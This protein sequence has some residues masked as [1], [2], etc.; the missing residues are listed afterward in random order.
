MLGYIRK[1][2]P[3]GVRIVYEVEGKSVCYFL[4]NYRG[5]ERA[6]HVAKVV[7]PGCETRAARRAI[8]LVLAGIC[9]ELNATGESMR[10]LD[11]E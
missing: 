11:W 6:G 10:W 3:D 5:I 8:G 9:R 1:N 7:H 2:L 4:L